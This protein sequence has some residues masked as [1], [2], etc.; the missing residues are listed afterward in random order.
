MVCV[1]SRCS[2]VAVAISVQPIYRARPSPRPCPARP[3]PARRGPGD[4]D[5]TGSR[6]GTLIY[7]WPLFGR[8]RGPSRKSNSLF[9]KLEKRQQPHRWNYS[10]GSIGQLSTDI[11]FSRTTNDERRR[12]E[13]AFCPCNLQQ[14]ITQ[15]SKSNTKWCHLV[16][17]SINGSSMNIPSVSFALLLNKTLLYALYLK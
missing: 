4:H 13:T 2:V 17:F 9:M 7:R 3:G 1:M 16:N 15:T 5:Q 6:R 10:T 12:R 14:I 11:S 8:P